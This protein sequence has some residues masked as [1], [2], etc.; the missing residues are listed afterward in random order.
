MRQ[1]QQ[2]NQQLTQQ[3]EAYK[4]SEYE[5]ALNQEG[6]DWMKATSGGAP[7]DITKLPGM[8]PYLDIYNSAAA[9]QKGQRMG[10]GLL[11]YGAANANP[12]LVA[13]LAQQDES[14]RRQDAAAQLNNA[15]AL[16]NA[17]V[18]GTALPLINIGENRA[19]S[20]IGAYGNIASTGANMAN[21]GADR[22]ARFQVRPGF[23]A[24]LLNNATAGIGQGAIAAAMPTGGL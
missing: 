6:V 5:Q 9:K 16:R 2:Q 12:A 13:S 3:I 15:F 20:K 23:W 22:W 4:P 24:N 8:A 10:L 1:Y 21:A 11:S 7:L 17:E 19:Q 14:H 18:R